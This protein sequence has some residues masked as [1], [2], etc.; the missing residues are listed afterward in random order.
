MKAVLTHPAS[1][2][3]KACLRLGVFVKRM[4]FKTNAKH[5]FKGE[6]VTFQRGKLCSLLMVNAEKWGAKIKK[7]G[8]SQ[9]AIAYLFSV[10]SLVFPPFSVFKIAYHENPFAFSPSALS[11]MP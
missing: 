10:A 6:S 2:L 5:C 4:K 11:G 9:L 1:K 3:S 7:W 8:R